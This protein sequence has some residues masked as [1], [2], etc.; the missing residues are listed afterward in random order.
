[1]IVLAIY[2][3]F[4]YAKSSTELPEEIKQGKETVKL[5]NGLTFCAKQI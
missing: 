1:M 4:S 2:F 3:L 5:S